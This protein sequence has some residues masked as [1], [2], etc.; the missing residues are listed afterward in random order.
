MNNLR[1]YFGVASIII[2]LLAAALAF[3]NLRG[4]SSPPPALLD[5]DFTLWTQTGNSTRP[6]VWTL[7]SNVQQDQLGVERTSLDGRDSLRLSLRQNATAQGGTFVS[8]S[9][10]LDGTRLA[11]LMNSTIGLWVFKEPCNC[12]ADPFGDYSVVLSVQINDGFR[13]VSFVFTDK[14][15]GVV[16]FLGHRVIFIPT[17]SGEWSYREV[18]FRQEYLLA[19]WPMPVSAMFSLYF[20]V[21]SNSLGWHTV[22]ISQLR[23]STN[24]P[25]ASLEVTEISDVARTYQTFKVGENLAML[26]MGL[27]EER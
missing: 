9:E 21:G 24:A 14:L 20:E 4:T 10:T 25:L 11:Q 2:L 5:P 23:S 22:Y 1:R 3:L 17:P 19:Q 12:D 8:L 16:T 13:L 27:G 26:T 6:M 15:Q 7:Q 18:N